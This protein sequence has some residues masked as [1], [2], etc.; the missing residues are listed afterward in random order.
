MNQ[1]YLYKCEIC[2][3]VI[4]LIKEEPSVCVID[5]CKVCEE[6]REFIYLGEFK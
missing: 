6:L 3:V 2:N 1:H 4:A 5:I